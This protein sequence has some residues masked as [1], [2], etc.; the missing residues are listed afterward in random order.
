MYLKNITLRGFKSFANKCQ[1]IFEP[2]ISVI[3]GPNGS[4]KSNVADAISWVLGEQ[5]PKSLRGNTMG[6]VIFRS[7]KEEMGIAEVSLLFDN[8][9]RLFDLE[10]KDVRITRRVYSEG[11]SDYFINSSPCRLM[12]LQE[13]I[14]D[15]GIGKGLHVIINQG[16]INEIALLKPEERKIVIDEV[17]G[18]SKHKD[19]RKRTLSKLE[20]VKED[21]FRLE[22]LM[23]EIKR[24]M[25]PLKIEAEKAR[26]YADAANEL[27]NHEVSLALARLNMLNNEWDRHKENYGKYKSRLQE[28]SDRIVEVEKEKSDIIKN[29]GSKQ[30][31]FELWRSR[32]EMF[33]GDRN[34]LENIIALIDSKRNVF[35][36]LYNMFDLEIRNSSR[37]EEDPG[38]NLENVAKFSHSFLAGLLEKLSAVEELFLKFILKIKKLPIQ[39]EQVGELEDDAS[40]ITSRI[41]EL[42][43]DIDNREKINGAEK[44][45]EVRAKALRL[46]EDKK[47][48]YRRR[49]EKT[50]ILRE[51]CKTNLKHSKRAVEILKIYYNFSGRI[52]TRLDPEFERRKNL[53][54]GDR[55]MID[56]CND[57]LNQLNLE[58]TGLEG[59]LYKSDLQREQIREKVREITANIID[60]YN[61][62]IEYAGKIYKPSINMAESEEKARQL[63]VRLRNLG[64]VNP[65]A[66][67]E[68]KKIRQRYDFLDSQK[69]DLVESRKG[70]QE[71]IMEMNK[72]ISDIFLK[73]FDVINESFRQYFKI[74]FPFGEGEMYL[75]RTNSN[76]DDDE[77]LGVEL[78]ADIGNSKLVPLSLL[79]GGE[80]SLVS[81]AFLFSVFSTKT[82]PFYVFDEVDA[83]LDDANINRFLSLVK[84]FSEKQQIIIITHQK[85]TMEIA[86]TIYGVSMQSDGISKVV[87][88]KIGAN[89]SVKTGGQGNNDIMERISDA[90]VV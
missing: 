62:S 50:G 5:S 25:D 34:R 40:V 24:T 22:D 12:D 46:A 74:L 29:I 23:G 2:G 27:K 69:L 66:A 88:E 61:I 17:L 32:I 55:E 45:K 10:F 84:K 26:R 60:N 67:Q 44:L 9:D 36:T 4:G 18:I 52:K 86:D 59:N 72:K 56:S 68:Y 89:G 70:L 71:L 87:S 30:A 57:K 13:L 75:D 21:I 58:K 53:I 73:N 8:S 49:I 38:S 82:S 54:S 64:A 7:K 11:G 63:K 39:Q 20:K 47:E 51:L 78:K 1:L 85:R 14:A 81:L 33:E 19:R 37:D 80:K 42:F 16:Q 28:V 3:V 48:R 77:D 79:S 31:D 90:D 43:V 35:S 76:H 41:R 15:S 65:N 83:A 6:D